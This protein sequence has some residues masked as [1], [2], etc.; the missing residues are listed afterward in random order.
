MFNFYTRLPRKTALRVLAVLMGL[1]VFGTQMPGLWRDAVF[2]ATHLPWQL[3]KVAHFV[4]FAGLA[5]L[6]HVRP[7]AWRLPWVLA[8]ALLV[9]MATEGMQFWAAGR[10]PSWWDVGIDMAGALV[11]LTFARLV[12]G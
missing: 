8:G 6:G 9:A 10:S 1:L 2:E 3:T 5:C 4:L 11:G 7:V 12:K